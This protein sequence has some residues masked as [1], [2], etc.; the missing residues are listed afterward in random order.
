MRYAVSRFVLLFAWWTAGA[1]G[2]DAPPQPLDVEDPDPVSIDTIVTSIRMRPDSAIDIGFL[3]ASPLWVGAEALSKDGEILY[4][5]WLD[6][7]RFSWS[8]S[9]PDVAA[10]ADTTCASSGGRC[11]LLTG[12]SEGTAVITATIQGVTDSITVAVRD[13]ARVAWST[14]IGPGNGMSR[15]VTIGPGG[16]IYV[17]TDDPATSQSA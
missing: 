14:P 10:L 9:D 13:R 1:C 8:S 12:V 5:S 3:H 11:R 2:G 16:T 17:G 4:R 15:H 7:T 6:H